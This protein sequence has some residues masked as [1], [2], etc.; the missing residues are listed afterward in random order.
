MA[1]LKLISAIASL[2]DN[3]MKTDN[4]FGICDND[5]RA[6]SDSRKQA[7]A[8]ACVKEK[9]WAVYVARAVERFAT[10]WETAVPSLET[11]DISSLNTSETNILWSA[12]MMPP[13]GENVSD[14]HSKKNSSNCTNCNL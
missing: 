8:A 14:S 1:H 7:Q 4:L 9:R 6:F 5:A 11:T 2:R 12:E 13:L 3:V 10:W